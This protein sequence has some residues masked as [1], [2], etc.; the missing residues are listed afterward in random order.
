GG[1][2]IQDGDRGCVDRRSS[3]DCEFA[4][5]PPI[6]VVDIDTA[7]HVAFDEGMMC[8]PTPIHIAQDIKPSKDCVRHTTIAVEVDVASCDLELIGPNVNRVTVAVQIVHSHS[9]QHAPSH[10]YVLSD[11]HAEP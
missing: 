4:R 9:S 8:A 6:G 10:F 11:I 7:I 1:G 5:M 3:T 2:G